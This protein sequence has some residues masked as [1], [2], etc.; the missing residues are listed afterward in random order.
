MVLI[1]KWDL[2]EKETATAESFTQKIHEKLAPMNDVPV[3][4]ISATEKQ[5]IHKAL[6]VGLEVFENRTRKITTSK[7]NDF[8]KEITEKHPPPS[9]RGKF[10]SIKYATQL[11]TYYPAFAF[12]C[13]HPKHV[14]E[15]YRNYVE[16]QLREQYNFSGCPIGIY[17]RQK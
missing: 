13:N 17:F 6:K 12:F 3:I 4:F 11:P 7:L 16:N 14:K 9:H 1:N 8:I 2:I 5:R 15:S 10:I